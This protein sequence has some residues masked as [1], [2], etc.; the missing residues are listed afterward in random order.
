[1][2]MGMKTGEEKGGRWILRVNNQP[3]TRSGLSRTET[4]STPLAP[5]IPFRC[6]EWG[7]SHRSPPAP[8]PNVKC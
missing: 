4:E 7:S 1:M 8:H 2:R 3:T 6:S 5:T